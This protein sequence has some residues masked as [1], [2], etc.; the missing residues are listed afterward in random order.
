MKKDVLDRLPNHERAWV[1][2]FQTFNALERA[3]ELELGKV[4][5][6]T[7]EAAVLFALKTA[8]EPTTPA[9][10]AR[11]LY[12]EA[13]TMS[14]LLN[15]MEK[16]GLVKKSKDLEAKNQIRVSLTEKG[17]EALRRQN[18]AR[19]SVNVT[20]CLSDKEFGVLMVCSDKLHDK[21]IELIR[22]MQPGPWE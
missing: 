10:L 7:A 2:L 1:R 11:W 8:K 21:A 5:L 15:R 19:S 17:E 12:R 22:K 6:T 20:S 18:D 13:H 16:D 3:R 4:G 14:G 9:K